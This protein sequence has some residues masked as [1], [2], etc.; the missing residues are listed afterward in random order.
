MKWLALCLLPLV[1]ASVVTAATVTVTSTS[2]NNGTLISLA[3]SIMND[4]W[5]TYPST[6]DQLQ[7][8]SLQL[9]EGSGEVWYF[10]VIS[11]R[12]A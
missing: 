11:A 12:C 5:N 3:A 1:A 8:L 6:T 10:T 9:T 2:S 4:V 7:F